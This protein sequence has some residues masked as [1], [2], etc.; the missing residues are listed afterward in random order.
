MS[1]PHLAG[2]SLL[3]LGTI[4]TGLYVAVEGIDKIDINSNATNQFLTVSGF[5][6]GTFLY[7]AVIVVALA[8]LQLMIFGIHHRTGQT[9]SSMRSFLLLSG[10]FSVVFG[11]ILLMQGAV[12][13]NHKNNGS[14]TPITVDD[15]RRPVEVGIVAGGLAVAS[16][17]GLILSCVSYKSRI[18]SLLY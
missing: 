18:T 3:L 16:G 1:T 15:G 5:E 17:A 13:F 10:I 12:V 9:D 6:R 14:G 11:S 7:A 8:V 2:Q 4:G